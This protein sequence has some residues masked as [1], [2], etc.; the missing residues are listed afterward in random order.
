MCSAFINHEDITFNMSMFILIGKF[1]ED[2]I[3]TDHAM[4][5]IRLII[6]V[7]GNQD[8]TLYVSYI[9]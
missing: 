8:I 6:G 2:P 5:Q 1:E 3:K 4:Q 7:F 9:V